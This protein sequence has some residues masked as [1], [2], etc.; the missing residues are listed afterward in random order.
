[1]VFFFV[2]NEITF[3]WASYG[4]YFLPE[5]RLKFIAGISRTPL[6]S[7]MYNICTLR[8]IIVSS[9]LVN[10]LWLCVTQAAGY[11]FDV[12]GVPCLG[13]RYRSE[14]PGD[15]FKLDANL[16]GQEEEM[17][18]LFQDSRFYILRCVK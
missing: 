5:R 17:N 6:V 14:N 2:V 12:A 18:P 11:F 1:M 16:K 9:I 10:M 4:F 8:T 13:T 15:D 3:F 7:F